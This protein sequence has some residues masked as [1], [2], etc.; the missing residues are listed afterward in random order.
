MRHVAN[1]RIG[2]KREVLAEQKFIF[3][4]PEN[5]SSFMNMCLQ[6]KKLMF[7]ELKISV[8]SNYAIISRSRQLAVFSLATSSSSL[9]IIDLQTTTIP[10][11]VMFFYESI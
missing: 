2:R 4:T 8:L 10:P 6:I 11:F 7:L 9:Y 1:T 5:S 3:G